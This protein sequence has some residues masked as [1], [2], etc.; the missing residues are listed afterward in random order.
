MEHTVVGHAREVLQCV[1]A[2]VLSLLQVS[3]LF[4]PYL[5]H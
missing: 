5:V 4:L 2:F 1:E 3:T